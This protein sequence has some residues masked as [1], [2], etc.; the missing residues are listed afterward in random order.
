MSK[1]I[2]RKITTTVPK[3]ETAAVRLKLLQDNAARVYVCRVAGVAMGTKENIHPQYGVSYG[4]IG[5]FAKINP[6][7]SR[8]DAAALW[9]NE[10][11]V[12]PIKAAL[13]GGSTSV[14]FMADI[15]AVYAEKGATGF[16]YVLETHGE[17]KADPLAGLLGS[18]PAMP[19]LPA[20][21]A[22]TPAKGKKG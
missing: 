3:S 19:A 16:Q 12:L 11:L 15:W 9:S 18:A 14:Q 2:T 22:D 10:S 13:D 6:N 5:T 7:G 21:V 1:I 8:E 20:P 17:E 4:L